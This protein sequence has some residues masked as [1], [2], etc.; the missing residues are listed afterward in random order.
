MQTA[1]D[2]TMAESP[3]RTE[4]LFAAALALANA[5]ERAAYLDQACGGDAALR[6]RVEALLRAHERAGHLLDRPV[7]GGLEW[8]GAYLP[9]GEQQG[10]TIAGR[11]KLLEEIGEG[12]MG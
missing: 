3:D 11:Y 10:T 6:G 4:T 2:R 1:E 7:P 5:A 9:R 8:T 12:G